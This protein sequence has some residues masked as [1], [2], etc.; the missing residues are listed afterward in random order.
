MLRPGTSYYIYIS[1]DIMI[2]THCHANSSSL[3]HLYLPFHSSGGSIILY[4]TW[5]VICIDDILEVWQHHVKKCLN[6]GQG[7]NSNLR[8]PW[9]GLSGS[10]HSE[11]SQFLLG[12]IIGRYIEMSKQRSSNFPRRNLEKLHFETLPVV[13]LT[14]KHQDFFFYRDTPLISYS[15]GSFL[16]R[17]LKIFNFE[18]LWYFETWTQKPR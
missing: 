15:S 4:E 3:F 17:S 16:W 12:D 7:F 8:S 6:P 5:I 13:F 18:T 11:T 9:P 1:I 2:L 10:K 14:R